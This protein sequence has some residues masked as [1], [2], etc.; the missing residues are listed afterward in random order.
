MNYA[1][2]WNPVKSSL[3]LAG[4][5]INKRWTEAYKQELYDSLYLRD[6]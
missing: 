2:A 1:D 4:A 5:S 6:Q 3:I